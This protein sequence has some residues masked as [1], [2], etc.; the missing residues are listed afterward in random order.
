MRRYWPWILPLAM[1][2]G[3]FYLSHIP[4]DLLP[5]IFPNADK[6][7]HGLLYAML[8]A[9]MLW[10]LVSSKGMLSSTLCGWGIALSTLYGILD[11]W[12]Q[13]YVPG[14]SVEAADVIADAVGALVGVLLYFVV[15]WYRARRY[16]RIR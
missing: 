10:A 1:M 8:G 7:V 5:S 15:R 12:H 4:G 16:V 6:L 9:L 2:G 11:E 14:R 3:I 13:W